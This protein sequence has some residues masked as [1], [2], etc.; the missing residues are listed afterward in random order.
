MF[1]LAREI[2]KDGSVAFLRGQVN[3]GQ[4]IQTLYNKKQNDTWD[5]THTWQIYYLEKNQTKKL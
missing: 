4:L 5:Q 1:S 3:K 2:T